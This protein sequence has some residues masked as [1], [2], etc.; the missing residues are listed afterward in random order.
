MTI[1]VR[2]WL[3]WGVLSHE[4]VRETL[5][6]AVARWSAQWFA[7]PG[8]AVAV[9]GVRAA[10]TDPRPEGDG[11]GWRI[12]RTA[13]AVRCG[14]AAL[15]R[16]VHRA[17]DLRVEAPHPTSADLR[18]LS[19]LEEKLLESLAVAVEG[20]LGIVDRSRPPA[21]K[22]DDPLCDGG[23]VLV[24]LAEPSGREVLTLAVPAETLF[25]HVK[26]ALGRPAAGNGRLQPLAEALGEVRIPL[27]AQIGKVELT[28][29]ELN[30]LGVGDVLVLDRRLDEAVDIAGLLSHDVFAKAVLTQAD[31]GLAL[32]FNV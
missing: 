12:Y 15:S 6:Q 11:T 22:V 23:G 29:S 16:L 2:E 8:V 5:E 13:V 10:M 9:A 20:A 14:R 1:N 30:E 28:L 27:E 3:P 18:I 21:G 24:S 7:T 4:A 26:A 25:R 17:L 31:D 32:M 19:G